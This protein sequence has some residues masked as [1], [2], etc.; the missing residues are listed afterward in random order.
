MVNSKPCG[1]F[2]E[3]Y[4]DRKHEEWLFREQFCHKCHPQQEKL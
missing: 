1:C 3:R 4:Y 2:L